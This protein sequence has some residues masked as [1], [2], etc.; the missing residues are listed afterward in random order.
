MCRVLWK[1][2]IQT[3]IHRRR[4]PHKNKGRNQMSYFTAKDIKIARNPPKAERTW[5]NSRSQHSERWC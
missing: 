5:K 3:G 4:V 2:K 1:E